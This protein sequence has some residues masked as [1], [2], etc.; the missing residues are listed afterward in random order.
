MAY[1][2]VVIVGGGFGGI[3]AAIALKRADVDVLVADKTNHHLFQPLL[4]QVATAALS[5]DNIAVPIRS[6]LSRQKNATVIMAHIIK[7]DR[8]R[9]VVIS[10]DGEEFPF[11]YLVVATGA[12]HSYFGHN[13]WEKYAPGLKTI[14][15]AVTIRERILLAFEKAERSDSIK[16]AIKYLRF[17]VIG[18]GPTGVEMA[19]AIAEISRKTL[20]NDFRKIKPEQS[21]IFLIEGLPCILSSYPAA[22]SEIAE[23]DLEKLGVKVLTNTKVTDV[24]SNGISIGDKFIETSNII[25]AAGNEASRL[26]KTLDVPLDRQGRVLINP[27]LSI[28]DSPNIFV[29]GDAACLQDKNG[30]PLPGIAP[31]AIQQGIYVADLIKKKIQSDKRHPFVYLDKGSMATIGKAKAIATIGKFSFSGHIA[32]IMWGLVHI[33]YLITFQNRLIVGI[34]WIYSYLTGSRHV[35]AITSSIEDKDSSVIGN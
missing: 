10:F 13:D 8:K 20:F 9:Q 12:M 2:K 18:G 25:W 31:V 30:K 4:Y 19:G 11:D 35:R 21:E 22:L 27:D 15:D 5:S 3:N 28:P 16:E 14:A 34:R 29:I 6:I 1:T 23:R 26:L 7:V 33:L 17:V 32:F 24:K